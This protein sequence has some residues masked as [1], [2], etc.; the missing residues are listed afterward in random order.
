MRSVYFLLSFVTI[1][2]VVGLLMVFGTTSAEVIDRN[3]NISTHHAL[4]K[5][6]IYGCLG[7]IVAL[8][9]YFFGYQKVVEFAPH[10]FYGCT[11]CLLLV[12]LPGVGRLI[13][14]AHRWIFLGPIS[15]Q[16]SDSHQSRNY[17]YQKHSL[18]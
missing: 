6:L 15:F 13:N 11:L 16:P 14:G 9:V 3:L 5:Q 12:F 8:L 4:I 10:L 2:F 17:H 18:L 7:I 1:L